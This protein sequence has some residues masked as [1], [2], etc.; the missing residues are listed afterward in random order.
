MTRNDRA[1]PLRQVLD[2]SCRHGFVTDIE[3]DALPSDLGEQTVSAG[4]WDGNVA[5]SCCFNKGG[6]S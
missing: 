5:Q 3:M 4:Y 2:G 6:K 1:K